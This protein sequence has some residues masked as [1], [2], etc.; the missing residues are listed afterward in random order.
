MKFIYII[1]LLL[2]QKISNAQ[3]NLVQNGDFEFY[4]ACPTLDGEIIKAVPW[5][6]PYVPGS[7]TDYFNACATANVGVPVN[8]IGHQPAHSGN[9]YS[10][11]QVYSPGFNG[12]EY[13]EIELTDTLSANTTYCINLYVSK[14]AYATA[15]DG[16]GCY[17]SENAIFYYWPPYNVLNYMPQVD[18]AGNI[19]TDTLNW[20]RLHGEFVASG[21][22]K[23]LTIG[24]FRYD[25]LTMTDPPNP[26][27]NGY[28]Y[29]DD[30]SVTVGPCNTYVTEPA[31]QLNIVIS[32]N[33]L[34]GII[35][36]SNNGHSEFDITI[37]TT[38]GAFV[39][40]AN[41]ISDV[42]TIACDGWTAGVYFLTATS[43]ENKTTR[44]IIRY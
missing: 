43:G 15:T 27:Q 32:P 17:F 9:G 18:F 23:Y 22:E 33:P 37:Q 5:F 19:L 26:N 36:V 3:I 34:Q 12:R 44:K 39:Y 21:V 35:T 10:G 13:L 7:S 6:Q 14:P 24:N 28:L 40:S 1:C 20:I 31:S 42:L 2:I 30:V 16:I 4:S 8:F 25:S 38:L 29:I 41:G 11:I